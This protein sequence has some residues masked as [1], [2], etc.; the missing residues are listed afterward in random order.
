MTGRKREKTKINKIKYEKGDMMININEIQRIIRSYFENLH[1]HK[2]ENP[3]EM[4]EFL[5]VQN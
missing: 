5:D 1:S 3:E 4:V 2:L